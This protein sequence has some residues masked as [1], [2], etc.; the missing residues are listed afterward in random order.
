[1]PPSFFSL[2]AFAPGAVVT[3]VSPANVNHAADTA[4]AT[5]E[6][7][8]RVPASS[9]LFLPQRNQNKYDADRRRNR[10]SGESDGRDFGAEMKTFLQSCSKTDQKEKKAQVDQD[11]PDRFFVI[12]RDSHGRK[13]SNTITRQNSSALFESK[14]LIGWCAGLSL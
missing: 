5:E 13:E 14:A 6:M 4:A 12:G 8:F 3:G 1:L 9:P 7:L 10:G 11:Y 2:D